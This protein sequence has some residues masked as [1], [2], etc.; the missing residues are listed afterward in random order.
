MSERSLSNRENNALPSSD[1]SS[2]PDWSIVANMARKDAS[3]ETSKNFGWYNTKN[4][5][6]YIKDRFSENLEMLEGIGDAHTIQLYESLMEE[7]PQ[8]RIVKLCD[9]A[10]NDD[11]ASFGHANY[12]DET[13][14]YLP[15]ISF[16]FSHR[17]D[18][19]VDKTRELERQLPSNDDRLGR[20]Y[21]TKRL[22][23]TIGAD[24]KKCIKNKKL[25]ADKILLHEFGHA[26]DFI[27]NFLRPQY[28]SISGDSRGAEALYRAS[29]IDG[30][31]RREYELQSPD[32]SFEFLRRHSEE[33]RKSE[34]RLKAMGI[35][36]YDEYLYARHQYY[37]D[38]PDEA[39]ADKFAYDYIMRHYD[40]YF[41]SD[42]R[43][44]EKVYVNDQ[45]EIKL[46]KDFVHILGLQ[47][48]LGVEIDR[49]DDERKSVKHASGFLAFNMY[50]GKSVYLYE[51]GDPKNP[52][53]K[54]RI[55][56]GISEMTLKPVKDEDAGKINHYVFFKDENGVEYHIS[57]TKEEPESVLC[58]PNEMAEELGLQVGDKVQLIEHL[59]S[60]ART[61]DFDKLERTNTRMIEGEVLRIDGDRKGEN[62][63]INY[64][65][66]NTATGL[67][68]PP[69]RKWKRWYV[70]NY[71]ILPL[72]DDLKRNNNI[73]S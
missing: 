51:N 45:R 50:V 36:N 4:T 33:W 24:W 65:I 49:L 38:Q 47:Q 63:V 20:K 44:Y 30:V 56:R 13:G 7:Y 21:S 31:N 40:D 61:I 8:V 55:C 25:I 52:G 48:G 64:Q 68:Y 43:Q 34:R 71:E 15:E 3:S 66:G 23:F 29:K 11:N 6:D 70:G 60:D 54:W 28:E 59:E 53:E 46:D 1:E 72:P 35:E 62:V 58:S 22:A 9:R 16:R 27:E 67:N 5:R 18:Y 73:S 10:E 39:Y 26:Y 69:I 12:S 2:S 17:G 42:P 57:R 19:A 41:T 32:G 14:N 37:R